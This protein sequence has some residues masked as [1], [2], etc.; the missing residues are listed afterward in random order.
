MLHKQHQSIMKR[1]VDSTAN[2]TDA[3]SCHLISNL[4]LLFVSGAKILL[5]PTNPFNLSN[6]NAFND[7]VTGLGCSATVLTGAY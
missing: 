4:V 3:T 5:Q 2:S 6:G 1:Q 7:K